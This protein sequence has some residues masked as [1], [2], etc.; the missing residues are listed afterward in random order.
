MDRITTA[1]CFKKKNN[2]VLH[3]RV[4]QIGSLKIY[5]KVYR[6]KTHQF[7]S[8]S[9]FFEKSNVWFSFLFTLVAIVFLHNL[10][11]FYIG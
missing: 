11:I 3:H 2:Y 9:L 8:D 5:Q 1:S 10:S 6:S 7:V 4:F